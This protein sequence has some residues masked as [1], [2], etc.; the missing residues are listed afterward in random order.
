MRAWNELRL[1]VSA[2]LLSKPPC[3]SV[4][5]VL[6]DGAKRNK[7]PFEAVVVSYFDGA[8]VQLLEKLDISAL[9]VQF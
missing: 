9:T 4:L 5:S 3:R 7:V 2:A 8:E 1:R 6:F